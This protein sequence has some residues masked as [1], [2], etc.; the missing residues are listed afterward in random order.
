ML[1]DDY[2]D[3]Q[4][5][6]EKKYGLKTIVLMEVGSFFEMYGV[7][8]ETEK[9]GDVQTIAELLNIQLS[10]R[11]KNILENNRSNSLMAGFPSISLKRFLNILIDTN[12]TVVLIE[13]VT[14]P[15]NPQREV[16][17]IYSP[18]TYIDDIENKFTNYIISVYLEEEI[19]I[20][21]KTEVFLLGMCAIDLTTGK[22]IIYQNNRI[23]FEK[24]SV[25]EEIFRFIEN[26][27]S[28]EV[29]FYSSFLNIISKEDIVRCISGN[30]R[31]LNIQYNCIDKEFLKINFINSFLKKV[32]P[33]HGMLTP[34]EFLDLENMYQAS[35]ALIMLINYAY[36][37]NEKIIEKLNKPMI[38]EYHEH[39]ILYHNATY[40]LNITNHNG[41]KSVFD[42]INKT[43]TPMG[44]RLLKYRLHNPIINTSELNSRYRMIDL[45]LQHRE[46][47]NNIVIRFKGVNDIERLIRR[48]N[49]KLL[50]P[51]EI[52]NLYISI[53]NGYNIF[54]ECKYIYN[55]EISKLNEEL[56]EKMEL[57]LKNCSQIFDLSVIG[58]YNMNNIDNSFINE[59]QSEDI[60]QLKKDKEEIIKFFDDEAE[61]LSDLI[62][63]G[64]GFVKSESN[65]RDGFFL[66][67]TVKRADLLKERL[68]DEDKSDEYEIKKYIANNV[69][70]TSEELQNRSDKLILLNR[71]I[72]SIVKEFYLKSLEELSNQFSNLLNQVSYILS[73]IDVIVSSAKCSIQ[74]NYVKPE[75]MERPENNSSSRIEIKGLR[76]P[77]IERL[78]DTGQYIG[79][80]IQLSDKEENLGILLYGVNGVGKSSLGKAL[81]INIVLAQM[82]MYVACEEMS[83]IPYSKIFTRI[84][85]DDNIFKG[86]SSFVLEM[87]ELKSIIKFADQNSIV[88]GD[89]ICKGTEEISA[90]SIITSCIQNFHDKGVNFV[91]ATHFHKLCDLQCI[92]ELKG[93]RMKHL[94]V[95]YDEE[96]DIMIYGRKL[97]D[98]AGDTLYGIEI[99]K[100]ILKDDHFIN[101]A[102]Q[103]RKELLKIDDELISGKKSNYS[104]QLYMDCC[105]ICKSTDN[106]DTH[107]IIEQNNFK[108]SD[109]IYEDGNLVDKNNID[110]LVVLCKTHH[111]MTHHDKLLIR[112]WIRSTN[113][114]TLDYK[115]INESDSPVRINEEK[116][117]K[118]IG[119]LKENSFNFDTPNYKLAIQLLR[120]NDINITQPTLKKYIGLEMSI[121]ID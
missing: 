76:H 119:V 58:K 26:F 41:N 87:N 27:N 108:V 23:R 92:R 86:M 39:L 37:H 106:L 84:N 67:L 77:I 40:Q 98:G 116:R 104:N 103:V 81:G 78:E 74:Y 91:M 2:F 63:K 17:K 73:I 99:A 70:I 48:L 118:V 49:L 46:I 110:N 94:S 101:R 31:L 45:M 72:E 107:H 109:F 6:Y 120:N 22:V 62:E 38:W 55:T 51:M 12:Y 85:G 34:I 56:L 25:L 100:Y 5:K 10:R 113:G 33:E 96:K 24:N 88:L 32:Y 9:I 53:E 117:Q 36:E 111:D 83:Y 50:H 8:N 14:P 93:I 80:D 59:G 71:K 114:R 69:K 42:I 115:Y 19:C 89:E 66:Y 82:G 47:M 11:N 13:Q 57:F 18:G 30:N 43:Q 28:K 112:G 35:V 90:L 97:I 29:I 52:L 68:K 1:I 4:I 54:K 121:H 16:T 60:D 7:N 105:N 15:P 102:F 64:S 75:I 20:K 61:K 3:Y 44:K 95:H 65:E 21:S 79:N